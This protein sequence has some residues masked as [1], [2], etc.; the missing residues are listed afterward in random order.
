MNDILTEKDYQ[1]YIISK[2]VENNG[3][4]ERSYKEFDRL[5]AIN[6]NALMRF[7]EK[8]QPEKLETLR[9]IHKNNTEKVIINTINNTETT[10]N[11]SRLD[12][13]KHGIDISYTHLDLVYDKPASNLN[14]ETVKLYKENIFTV[15]QEV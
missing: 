8:T 10:K 7:L 3:Y 1:N 12:I 14:K 11:S 5:Y 15:S 4:E 9:K 13:L 6:A 2:L